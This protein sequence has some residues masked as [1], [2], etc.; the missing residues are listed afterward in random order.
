MIRFIR[1]KLKSKKDRQIIVLVGASDTTGEA[2][3]ETMHG[4]GY[5]IELPASAWRSFCGTE[6]DS[7]VELHIS[8]QGSQQQPVPRLYGFRRELER[9]FFEEL[10]RVKDVG[11]AKALDAMSLPVPQ[12]AKAIV[13]R[14]VRTLKSLKG[15]GETTAEKIIAELRS[16]VAKYA[17]LPEDAAAMLE[18]PVDFK[19]EVQETLVKQ[20]QFK[21]LEAQQAIEEAIKRNAKISSAE[22]LFDEVLKGR[23]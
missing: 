15:V 2:G 23:K 16:R 8:S 1:G 19:V 10:I 20:L 17:L 21:P 6:L 4:V 12:I 11:S 7:D 18:E 5:Q 3:A 14:D 13:E 9:D 22:D